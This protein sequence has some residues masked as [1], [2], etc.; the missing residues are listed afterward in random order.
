M[1]TPDTSNVDDSS[2]SIKVSSVSVDGGISKGK[3]DAPISIIEFGDF[4]C[5]YY[6]LREY[7]PLLLQTGLIQDDNNERSLRITNKG[8]HF[9]KIYNTLPKY[10][11]KDQ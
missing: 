7:I 3:P 1:L 9:L 2:T 5:P 8:L 6:Q 4:Q 10:F 11:D